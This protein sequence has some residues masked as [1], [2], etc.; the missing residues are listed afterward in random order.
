MVSVATAIRRARCGSS[1]GIVAVVL[2]RSRSTGSRCH[3]LHVHCAIPAAAAAAAVTTISGLA[4]AAVTTLTL[5]GA[6]HRPAAQREGGS[7]QVQQRGAG[8]VSHDGQALRR[9]QAVGAP[10]KQLVGGGVKLCLNAIVGVQRR[11]HRRHVVF[12][13]VTR[14]RTRRRRLTP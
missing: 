14:R 7:Q 2:R 3:R 8:G 11:A 9:Q 1:I 6:L 13:H 5:A 4:A 10:H 12:Q